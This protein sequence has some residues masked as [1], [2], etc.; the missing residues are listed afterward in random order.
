MSSSLKLDVCPTCELASIDFTGYDPIAVIDALTS[1]SGRTPE[2]PRDIS[3]DELESIL[4]AEIREWEELDDD[5]G[6]SA[7]AML[8]NVPGVAVANYKC[9]L[10]R[11]TGT[12]L[13]GWARNTKRKAIEEGN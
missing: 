5:Y 4:L 6:M 9:D 8:K 10:N 3:E 12:C 7:A 11:F 13:L 2:D 1:L